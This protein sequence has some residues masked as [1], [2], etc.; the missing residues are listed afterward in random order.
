VRLGQTLGLSMIAE[1]IERTEQ[2]AELRPLLC[3][4]AQGYLWAK[5]ME[6]TV[7]GE[8]FGVVGARRRADSASLDAEAADARVVSLFG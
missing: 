7:F 6:G 3:G 8:L 1:G 5:P 2:L 4:M